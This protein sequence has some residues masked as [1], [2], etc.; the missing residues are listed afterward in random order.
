MEHEREMHVDPRIIAQV[1]ESLKHPENYVRMGR[2]K[3]KPTSTEYEAPSWNDTGMAPSSD[4]E[5][6]WGRGSSRDRDDQI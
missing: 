4:A 5:G 1:E 6:M 3:R 2:P